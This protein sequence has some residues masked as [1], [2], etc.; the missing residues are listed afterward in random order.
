MPRNTS[1]LECRSRKSRC[2]GTTPCLYCSKAKKQCL[3]EA[4]PS[5]TSLTRRNLDESE[6]R[7]E[8]LRSLLSS[9]N[10]GL[11][12]E[13]ALQQAK[14]AAEPNATV[15]SLENLDVAPVLKEFEWRETPLLSKPERSVGSS[16]AGDGMASLPA[17][18]GTSGYLGSSSGSSLL[19]T[20]FDLLPKTDVGV[21]PRSVDSPASQTSSPRTGTSQT[22]ITSVG[23]SDRLATAAVTER[24]ID[25]Y[26]TC[27]NAS[28]PIIH[29]SAFRKTYRDP[30][31]MRPTPIARLTYYMVLAVGHWSLSHGD[32]DENSPYYHSARNSISVHMLESGSMEAVQAFA[33]LGHYLQKRD[34][35]NTG[36]NYIGI[37]LRMALGLGLHRELPSSDAPVSAL[38]RQRRRQVWWTLFCFESGFSITTGR[39]LMINNTSTDALLPNNSEDTDSSPSGPHLQSVNHPTHN[40]AIIAQAPLAMIAND[41]Y[42]TITANNTTKPH[43]LD[44]QT[45]TALDARLS[46]WKDTLPPYFHTPNIPPWFHAPRAI[47]L[48]KHQNTRLLLW[49]STISIE[50][51]ASPVLNPSTHLT[52]TT[53][54]QTAAIE[55]IATISAFCAEH[56][57]GMQKGVAWYA[58]Y[59]LFQAAL[60]LDVFYLRHC[61]GGGEEAWERSIAA[62][63]E[64]LKGLGRVNAAAKKCLGVLERIHESLVGSGCAASDAEMKMHTPSAFGQVGLGQV[65]S[66]YEWILSADPSLFAFLD[67]FSMPAFLE[68]GGGF[69]GVDGLGGIGWMGGSLHGSV[70]GA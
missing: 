56:R 51:S 52:A 28:Y 13:A 33:L 23:V 32:E 63:R 14:Q 62:A 43:I 49:R 30:G 19:E 42:T 26:F 24:L 8:V 25:A 34:R 68:G 60:A 41:I 53:R 16:D 70:D 57:E 54:F 1:C 35:P 66:D 59:F 17:N 55:S 40:S 39:P 6:R 3:Y 69:S 44:F 5:R 37:A 12:I 58:T 47:L 46:T 64:C 7:C 65:Q 21:T 67:E 10:P 48:W 11:D 38:V 20:I 29:E 4:V 15:P 31:V 2:S 18:T 61:R 36:Y 50:R 9:L 45:A 22:A 27:Y